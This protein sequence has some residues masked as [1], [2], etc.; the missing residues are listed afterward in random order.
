MLKALRVG[1]SRYY[2]DQIF[3]QHLAFVKHN[4]DVLDEITVFAD[5][6][7]YGYW[8]P[9]YTAENVELLLLSQMYVKPE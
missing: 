5:F 9:E 6:S 8:S 1:Y 2:D 3:D 7:H 4:L